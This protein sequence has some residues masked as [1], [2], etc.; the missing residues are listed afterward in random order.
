MP[1]TRIYGIDLG[2]TYSC[3]A[4]VD[5][6][7]RPS[8][9]QNFEGEL[10]TPSAVHFENA[11]NIVVGKEAKNVSKLYPDRAVEF[12]KRYMGDATFS[13]E[14]DGH[15]YKPE[16]IS[17]YILRKLVDD[18]SQTVGEKITDVVI[19][20]PAYFGINERKATENAGVL[21]GLNVRY[22]LNEPTAAAICYGLD[23]SKGDQT[24]LVYDL[25][26]GTFD[27]TVIA[28]KG[29]NINVVVTGGK[30]TLGGKDWDDRLI[31]YLA[32]E[33]AAAYPDKGN[34]LDDNH[35][36]Q[37]LR[38]MAESAKKTITVREKSPLMVAHNGERVK[39][40]LTREKFEEITAD[41][42]E[43]TIS[44]TQEL[45][46][47]ARERGCDKIDQI[48]LVGGSSKM[49]YVVRRMQESFGGDI[50]LFEPDLA[51][52]K[53]AALMGV[54]ILAGEMI[55]EV[56]ADEQGVS[57]EEV[58]LDTVDART[59]EAAAQQ[60]ASTSGGTLRLPGKELAEMVRREIKIVSSKSFGI[61][62]NS[63]ED[64]E[65]EFVAFLIHNNTPLPAEITETGFGTLTANQRDVLLRIMEQSGEEASPN[66]AD[67]TQI[68]E[69]Q[70][71]ALPPNL[72][73]GSPIHVTFR[74]QEDGSL[75]VSALE[76]TSGQS[77][78]LDIKVEGIMSDEEVEQ[79]K[80]ILLKK[81]VS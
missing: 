54:K 26:G 18:A 28:M 13:Y 5:E 8:V 42:M 7:G 32:S 25:G 63:S 67:N 15:D 1:S 4:Y 53:G 46:E 48:L 20:C 30:R 12:V 50:Q 44:L 17:S 2:T 38:E 29:G 57:V 16:E 64:V 60:V 75:R 51:V 76:P 34:P 70:I 47:K 73:A 3:I 79:K 10:T 14:I 80:G 45:L 31:E 55:R 81:S 72:P 65:Q 58:N 52:A 19:T 39:V 6:T 43:Q 66:P 41:L 27:V 11:D 56:I 78:E 9:I 33:F 71:T 68:G 37:T 77:L 23:K 74:L 40:E 59:L 35:S 62:A 22:I 36:S 21:A 24:V 69:G 49:P 61:V